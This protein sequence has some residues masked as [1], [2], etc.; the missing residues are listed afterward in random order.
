MMFLA[1]IVISIFYNEVS[2]GDTTGVKN[3]GLVIYRDRVLEPP[4]EFTGIEEDTLRLNGIPYF[5]VRVTEEDRRERGKLL[6]DSVIEKIKAKLEKER[7]LW[8]R[9][10]KPEE[11]HELGVYAYEQAKKAKTYE[12]KKTIFARI[13][14]ESPHVDSTSIMGNAVLVYWKHDRPEAEYCIIPRKYTPPLTEEQRLE[15]RL[16]SRR[17][18]IERFWDRYNS[19]GTIA[20][21]GIAGHLYAPDR[22][23]RGTLKAIEKLRRGDTLTTMEKKRSVFF[24]RK[25]LK[26]FKRRLKRMREEE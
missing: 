7:L 10:P 25:L 13:M 12:K 5:P 23:T 19:G 22:A 11:T 14:A 16:E 6:P 18:A 1:L 3:K 15:R 8:K 20:F 4:F 26:L 2:A 24:E 9:P 21:G 17:S